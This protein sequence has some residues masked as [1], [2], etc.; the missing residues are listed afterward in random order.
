MLRAVLVHD[1]LAQ[2]VVPSLQLVPNDFVHLKVPFY[3]AIAV[4]SRALIVNYD[5]FRRVDVSIAQ[6]DAI[7]H[8]VFYHVRL[9]NTAAPGQYDQATADGP[10]DIVVDHLDS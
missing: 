4:E 5:V 1:V 2:A 3:V 6:V 10:S 8:A 9:E 7:V